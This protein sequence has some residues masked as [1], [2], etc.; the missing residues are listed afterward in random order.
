[1]HIAAAERVHNALSGGAGIHNSIAAKA[2]QFADVVK[3][4]RTLCRRS[5]ADDGQE[6]GGWASCCARRCHD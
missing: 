5:A 1:M 4:G 2:R 3:I 6:M